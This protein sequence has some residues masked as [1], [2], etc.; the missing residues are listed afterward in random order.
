M[1]DFKQ[2]LENALKKS[3]EKQMAQTHA[4]LTPVINQWDEEER[5]RGN[6]GRNLVTTN[7]SRA[8]FNYIRD[9][10]SKTKQEITKALTNQ[11]Y[12]ANSV[13]TLVTQMIRGDQAAM[14]KQGRVTTHLKTYV[15]IKNGT[16]IIRMKGAVRVKA[17]NSKSGRPS[18]QGIA[19][20]S[21]QDAPVLPTPTPVPTKTASVDELLSTL[22]F[23]QAIELY[24][25]LRVMLGDAVHGGGIPR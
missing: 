25:K 8:T 11:G 22:S 3:T 16:A 19:A 9:N 24:K 15:P 18:K 14:D 7:V 10:P 20:L 1:Q 12:N 21:V 17:V 5:A 2:A 4:Q 6:A 23:S 13:T